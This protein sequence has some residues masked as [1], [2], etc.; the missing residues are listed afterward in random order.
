MPD[1]EKT[2]NIDVFF[3]KIN[4]AAD[5]VS[6]K[7]VAV[8]P[9]A[10]EALL[11]LVQFK[12]VFDLA[13]GVALGCLCCVLIKFGVNRMGLAA[14]ITKEHGD[15]Y[16]NNEEMTWQ[17][18]GAVSFVVAAFTGVGSLISV[19]SFYPWLA[20]FYPEGAIAMKAL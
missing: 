16:S 10:A 20:A 3:G 2:D 9:E 15:R 4:E 8:A 11:N 12:G 14:E 1:I 6:A 19:L 13:S 5:I 17:A 7:L 18:V